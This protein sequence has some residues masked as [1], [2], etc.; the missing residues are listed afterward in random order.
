MRL[1]IYFYCMAF[2]NVS[3]NL[4]SGNSFTKVAGDL[5]IINSSLGKTAGI[6]DSV[7]GKISTLQK[8]QIL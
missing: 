1:C 6:L 2:L 3:L 4:L 8:F 5:N 7:K